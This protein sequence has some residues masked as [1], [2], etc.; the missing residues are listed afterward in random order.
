MGTSIQV[1]DVNQL[2]AAVSQKCDA[3]NRVNFD[4]GGHYIH[5]KATGVKTPMAREGGVY[6]FDMWVK[7]GKPSI[8]TVCNKQC[9][10]PPPPPPSI[11]R[12]S[13]NESGFARLDVELF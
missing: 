11:P 6:K 9:C 3:G 8:N 2:L 12:A 7:K 10:P 4:N 13:G 5:N 1:P